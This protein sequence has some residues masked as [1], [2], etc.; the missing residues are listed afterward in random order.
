MLSPVE[1]AWVSTAILLMRILLAGSL[2]VIKSRRRK[3]VVLRLPLKRMQYILIIKSCIKRFLQVP[4]QNLVK[5]I[6]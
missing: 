4:L 2:E 1:V 3:H 6:L 5:F